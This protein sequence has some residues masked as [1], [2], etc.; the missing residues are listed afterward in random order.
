MAVLQKII[1]R[2]KTI[3]KQNNRKQAQLE[4]QTK[5]FNNTG[6]TTTDTLQLLPQTSQ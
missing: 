4:E 6:Q 2:K 1:N 3:K 5:T